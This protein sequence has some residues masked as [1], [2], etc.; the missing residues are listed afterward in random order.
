MDRVEQIADE[1]SR[2]VPRLIR[3]MRTGF[4]APRSLTPAQLAV[5][6]AVHEHGSIT[7][8]KLS[9]ALRVSAPTVTGLLDRLKLGRYITRSIDTKDR[10]VV[11]IHITA[12]GQSEVRNLM[13]RIKNRWKTILAQLEPV[14]REG[15]LALVKKI[16]QVLDKENE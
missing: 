9:K 3:G 1:I 12:K 15:Y 4:I 13:V 10:R 2:L 16:L 5:L 11:N 6:L 8:G 14:D 7:S